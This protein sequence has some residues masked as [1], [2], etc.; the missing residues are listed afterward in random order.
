MLRHN[1]LSHLFH[2]RMATTSSFIMITGA[3]TGIGLAVTTELV[4]RGHAVFAGVRKQADADRLR[5]ELGEGCIPLLLDVTNAETIRSAVVTV[6]QHLQGRGLQCLINNAGIAHGG[7]LQH[8]PIESIRQ[9][10]EVNVLGLIAVTQA[11]LP[12]LGARASHEGKPGRII[13]ISSVGGKISPPFIA[14]Y[15]ATKHAVE[16]LSHSLR[17]ELRV[18]GIDVVI[19]GPGGVNTPIWDKVDD[20]EQFHDTAYYEPL[21]KFTEN[22]I[23][24]GK[25]GLTMET[26]GRQI[27][28]IVEVPKPKIRYALVRN[29]VPNWIIPRLLP[30]GILDK[31]IGGAL[32]LTKK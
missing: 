18:F 3:S 32:G 28:D 31:I 25:K 21:K 6:Q 24:S 15:V 23:A 4:R 27:A 8:I 20:V 22:F 9:D 16:G 29:R 12:F 2:H 14:P 26:I 5:A 17:R 10:F 19:V 30:N 13:N 1:F 11:I 7:P